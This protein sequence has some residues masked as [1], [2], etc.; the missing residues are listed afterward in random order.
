[1]SANDVIA[2]SRTPLRSAIGA[3]LRA[4]A[5]GLS[6]RG[7][8]AESVLGLI[9]VA[10]L[11]I[12][13]IGPLCAVLLQAFVPDL[14]FGDR[15]RGGLGNLLELF[16]RP[17]WQR[18]LTNSL[19]LASGAAVIGTAIGV[20][21]A[22]LR[23]SYRF[24]GRTSLDVLAWSL[25]ILPSF[26]LAQGWILF[27]S[28]GGLANQWLGLPFVYDLIF[29]PFGLI[30]IMSLKNFPYAYLTT[31]AALQ[32]RVEDHMNAARL[33]GARPARVLRTIRAPLLLPAILS[34]AVLIFVDSIGDFGL[35]SALATTYRFPTL[36]YTIYVAINQSPIRFDLAGVLSIYLTL[37]LLAA[38]T[39]YFWFLRRG[40]Y[41]FLT[42]KARQ[43]SA[44]KPRFAWALSA[45]AAAAIFVALVLP[46]GTSWLVSIMHDIGNGPR[47]DNL[48][49]SHY[50]AT[51]ADGARMRVALGNS[52]WIAAAAGIGSLII[53][54]P[55][56]YL[57]T[58]SNFRFFN[59]FIDLACTLSLAVPGVILGVGYIFI[60]NAPWLDRLG[61]SLYGHPFILALAA[62]SGAVP[63]AVRIILGAIA[64]VPRS[65]LSAA[66]LQGAGLGRRLA[67]IV[68][69]MAA[70][71]LVSAALTGFG[72]SV[73]DLATT[74]IL[75]PP[76]FAVL[77]V[78]I[79]RAFE[80]GY[81]GESTAATMAAGAITV[82][83]IV[84]AQNLAR[85]ALRRFSPPTEDSR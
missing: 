81:Y 62:I 12:L 66:A 39:L 13:V 54:F 85:R 28:K 46:I 37:I 60:W 53:T 73:F 52:L 14:F 10:A 72:S 2:S 16:N 84:A 68:A 42:S 5:S 4:S 30:L 3:A 7:L 79:T 44:P 51:L 55:A 18:S 75:H 40:R 34:G 1:M 45:V 29:S 50:A 77:P 24:P 19:T 22:L 9:V 74:A 41:D 48:T 71:A 36:P 32:W 64:Q 69:P 76:G 11:F 23:H 65:F 82:A 21:L 17:L 57:L 80:Q 56:A 61:L 15:A 25:L 31:S 27:A 83:F 35:P 38:V 20:G 47:L 58:F 8:S 49:I 33:C 26:V 63:I 59:R 67:G 70:L 78:H 43:T 6:G